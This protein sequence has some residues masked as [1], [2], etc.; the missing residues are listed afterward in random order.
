MSARARRSR[1][2]RRERRRRKA[3]IILGAA[4]AVSLP[5]AVVL[6]AAWRD[7]A[8]ARHEMANVVTLARPDQAALV[9][10]P[11]GRA[12]LVHELDDAART[13]T[14]ARQQLLRSRA[15]SF[16][17]AFPLTKTV[18]DQVLDVLRDGERAAKAT[19]ELIGE[20]DAAIA[21]GGVQDGLV[22]IA[23]LDRVRASAEHTRGVLL[24]LVRPSDERW[25]PVAAPR[26]RLDHSISSLALRLDG[27]ARGLRAAKSFFG[28]N[29]NRHYLLTFGNNAE[30]RDGAMPLSYGVLDVNGGRFELTHVGSIAELSL[31]APTSTPL[32]PGT[33]AV[34]GP[35]HPTQ[36]WQSVNATADFA[37]SGRAMAD[38]YQQATG[39]PVAGVV[40]I[41]VPSLAGL[42]GVIGPVTVAGIAGPV[43]ADN[44]GAVLL[45][46]QYDGVLPLADP[47]ARRDRLADVARAVFAQLRTGTYP[48][49]PL[50]RAMAGAGAGRHVQFWSGDDGEERFYEEAGLGGG[51][52]LVAPERTFHV[53]I[54]NRTA[55]KLDYFVHPTVTQTIRVT[56]RGDAVVSTT[57]HIENRAP[58]GARASYQLGPDN[59]TQAPGDYMGSV[60]LWGPP[61][62]SGEDGP[63]PTESG[64]Q[65]V[66]RDVLIKAGQA[67]DVTFPPAIIKSAVHNGRVDVRLVPQARLEPVDLHVTAAN[68]RGRISGVREFRG[69]WD[70]TVSLSFKVHG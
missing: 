1:R 67:A 69:A 54:E 12:Q 5:I 3:V 17:G 68:D 28:S 57:V 56:A 9:E 23:E 24:T 8:L 4:A 27:L 53:A 41:D 30:M 51:P 40:H 2:A 18:R 63:A 44:A 34:F 61:G 20:M 26:R 49:I 58:A 22:P 43:S 14:L 62:A 35:L 25:S 37:F 33:A 47:S 66:E 55:T 65:L 15:L 59:F 46:D 52:A 60:L 50:G 13:T 38:M 39:D 29:G 6:V 16:L 11:T 31:S 19:S 42:L 7:V 32:P 21:G 36:T 45:H 64:L 48:A 70:R 10:S